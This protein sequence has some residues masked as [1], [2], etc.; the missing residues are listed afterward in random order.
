MDIYFFDFIVH[1]KERGKKCENTY[2]I[3]IKER[4][5]P[6]FKSWRT[7]MPVRFCDSLQFISPEPTRRTEKDCSE[8][9]TI[10]CYEHEEL[11]L[12]FKTMDQR[13]MV[14]VFLHLSTNT[15]DIFLHRWSDLDQKYL[16]ISAD[17]LTAA[18]ERSV[19][20]ILR[21]FYIRSGKQISYFLL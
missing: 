14:A 15:I 3:L 5:N 21:S 13:T 19:Q 1:A 20:H 4:S 12:L 8:Y 18:E 6:F 7:I 10:T 9:R 16:R 2:Q 11:I 17:H